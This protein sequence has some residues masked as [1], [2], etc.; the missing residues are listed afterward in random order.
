MLDTNFIL[1]QKLS[2]CTTTSGTTIRFP[3]CALADVGAGAEARRLR[4][5]LHDGSGG[6]V[7]RAIPQGR[8][9]L[10]WVIGPVGTGE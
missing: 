7:R 5:A 9:G 6:R 3:R 1:F 2:Q 4:G 10:L 8:Q